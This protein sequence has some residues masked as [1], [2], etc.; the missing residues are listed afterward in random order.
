MPARIIRLDEIDE[1]GR[2]RWRDL[3][4]QAVEPNPFFEP[5]FVLPAAGVLAGDPAMLVSEDRSG[6]W[7]GAMPLVHAR[8]WRGVPARGHSSWRHDYSFFGAPLIR[9][10][11]E[12]RVCAEWLS[13]EELRL[14]PFLGLDLLDGDGPIHDALVDRASSLGRNPVTFEEHDRAALRRRAG[15]SRLS[16]G[17]SSKR[18]RENARLGR[19]LSEALGEEVEA[20]DRGEDP[21]AVEAFLQLEASGWKGSEHTAMA[22]EDSR[23]ELFRRLCAGFR[24]AGPPAVAQPAGGWAAGGDQVQPARRRRDLLLQDLFRRDLLQSSAPGFSWSAHLSIMRRTTSGS[25]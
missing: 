20:I 23:A 16:L 12:E 18:R 14:R 17:L 10:G 13:G 2:E 11:D 22:S 6:D 7:T 15:D 19:R 25:T 3:A 1:P 5:E 4:R 8:G 21:D 24:D 9:A